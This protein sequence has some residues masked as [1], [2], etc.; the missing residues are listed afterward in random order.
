ML[1]IPIW[2]FTPYDV[3]GIHIGTQLMGS[4]KLDKCFVSLQINV[5]TLCHHVTSVFRPYFCE[6]AKSVRLIVITLN[7]STTIVNFVLDGFCTLNETEG[8]ACGAFFRR[9][10]AVSQT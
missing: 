6:G 4:Q 8:N 9:A 1:G 7:V 3:D 10:I 2:T 5:Y